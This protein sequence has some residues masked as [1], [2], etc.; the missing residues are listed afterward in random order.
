M[1]E[2]IKQYILSAYKHESYIIRTKATYLYFFILMVFVISILGLVFHGDKGDLV[3]YT[4]VFLS[5]LAV[6]C[7]LRRGSLNQAVTVTVLTISMNICI[8]IMRFNFASYE[9]I[10]ETIME[11]FLSY[12]AVSLFAINRRH[13]IYT[14]ISN[15]GLTILHA[16]L[17]S[18]FTYSNTA[19]PAEAYKYF[20]GG[21]TAVL[22]AGFIVW[23]NYK[24]NEEALNILER[25]KDELEYLVQA[26]TKELKTANQKLKQ[27]NRELLE[28]SMFDPLTG[29]FN[30]RKILDKAFKLVQ[31]RIK[32]R[33]PISIVIIDIDHFKKI[34]D[35]YG[36]TVGDLAIRKVVDI[37]KR[38]LRENDYL[39]RIGGEEFLVILDY[40]NIADAVLL[41]N[42]IRAD[43]EAA[44]V[45]APLGVKF[46]MT[47]SV[48]ISHLAGDDSL[49]ELV[50]RA[51]KAL[52]DSKRQ[53]RNRVT[54]AV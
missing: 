38:S 23:A 52:Y 10:V 42:H 28:I 14:I 50:H 9:K 37:C 2:S 21:G 33:L 43:V 13:I 41:M 11:A 53:G 19:L 6:L 47:I 35:T 27:T 4:S 20:I 48:G 26:R 34:N 7:L 39:G 3:L 12:V 44:M 30:R 46:Q 36:H 1:F 22:L 18:R 24:V 8:D 51:D 49:E 25:S 31:L 15:T 17:I 5:F 29:I 16:I 40:T 54:S 32:D 45:T